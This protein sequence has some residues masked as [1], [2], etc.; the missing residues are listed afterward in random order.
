MESW[1]PYAENDAGDSAIHQR[2]V[3][4]LRLDDGEVWLIAQKVLDRRLVQ[5][6]VGLS[7]GAADSR[8]LCGRLRTRELDSGAVGRDGP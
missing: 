8:A 6:P 3:L 4:D 1:R 2:Q 5:L 7:A